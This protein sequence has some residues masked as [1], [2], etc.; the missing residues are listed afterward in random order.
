[1]GLEISRRYSSYNFHLISAK[2]YEDIG[3]HGGIQA[4]TFRDNRPILKLLWHFK[5]LTWESMGKPKM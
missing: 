5:I 1:M 3:K 2:P 4:I